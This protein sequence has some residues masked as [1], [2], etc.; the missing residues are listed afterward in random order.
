MNYRSHMVLAQVK[1]EVEPVNNLSNFPQKV[2]VEVGYLRIGV[3]SLSTMYADLIH[4]TPERCKEPLVFGLS[5]VLFHAS[6]LWLDVTAV[7]A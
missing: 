7:I 3:L 1:S 4:R 6:P 2:P 5:W